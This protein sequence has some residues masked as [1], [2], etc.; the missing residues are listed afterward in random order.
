MGLEIIKNKIYVG[1]G[2]THAPEDFKTQVEATKEALQGS[3]DVLQ[4]LGTTAG[5][6]A[7][8]YQVDIVNNVGGCDAF[9]GIMD[10]PSWGLGYE[11][12][13]AILRGKPVLL[14]AHTDSKVTRLALGTPQF[15]PSVTFERY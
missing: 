6:A 11:T 2:L 13:E 3:F 10:E 1:C 7:D 15:Q 14:V 4:F 9:L 12:R 8:V 5:T